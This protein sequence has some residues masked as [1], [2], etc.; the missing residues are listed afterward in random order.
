MLVHCYFTDGLFE[1]A[2]LMIE[3]FKYHNGEDMKFVLTTRD[4]KEKQIEHLNKIYSNLDIINEPLDYKRL[5][6]LTGITKEEALKV[7]KEVEMGKTFGES[8]KM[9]MWKRFASIDDRYRNSI[10][11]VM[12]KYK[13]EGSILHFDAD[14]YIRKPLDD[15]FELVEN[16]DFTITFRIKEIDRRKVF[17]CLL[18]IKTNKNGFAFMNA[19]KKRIDEIPSTEKPRGYGQYSC[20]LA[21]TDLKNSNIKWGNIP[22]KYIGKRSEE[23][24]PVW[25]GNNGSKKYNIISGREDFKKIKSGVK[26][27]LYSIGE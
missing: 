16:N 7:K 10:V 21:Y 3:S 6:R 5:E 22:E 2:C 14:M 23:N 9:M 26:P 13:K 20:Y 24:A 12:S 15:L 27:E 25:S 17:G 18:G 4:L 8:K 1:Y 19:W 11:E